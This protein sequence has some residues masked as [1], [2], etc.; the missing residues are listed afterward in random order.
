MSGNGT[1]AGGSQERLPG[2]APRVL[3]FPVCGLGAKMRSQGLSPR[4]RGS[5]TLRAALPACGV[6]QV[7]RGA[8]SGRWVPWSPSLRPS[9]GAAAGAAGSVEEGS[10]VLGGRGSQGCSSGCRALGS[11]GALPHSTGGQWG[12]QRSVKRRGRR[13]SRDP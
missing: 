11:G 5:G 9:R 1:V 8:S 13:K 7:A 12:P 6:W 3:R 10:A 4:C 2:A